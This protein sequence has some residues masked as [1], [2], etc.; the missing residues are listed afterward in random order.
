MKFLRE[1]LVHFLA[2]GALLFAVYGWL[3]RGADE[4]GPADR[5]V[6]VGEREMTWLAETWQRQRQRPPSAEELQG[7]LADYLREELLAR[8]ARALELDR[9]DT[10]VRRRLAQKMEFLLADTVSRA[11]PAEDDLRRL[12]A[13]RSDRFAAPARTSF[14]QVFVRAD[15]REG[16]AD[17]RASRLLAA[18]AAEPGRG[19]AE[20]GDPTLLPAEVVAADEREIA[21]QFGVDFARA[22]GELT[23]GEWRGP[24]RSAF[25]LHLVRVTGR[26]DGRPRGYDEVR[27]ELVAEWHRERDEA[28]Q[29]AYFAGLLR[30]YEIEVAESLRPLLAPALAA[31]GG[32]TK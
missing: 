17:E 24:L 10:V 19:I 9:D 13:A 26:E 25:G 3:G 2:A 20:L 6:V 29:Q 15:E 11:E 7:L 28:A 12:F 21:A 30:E 23:P 8:E 27:D 32:A 31:V 5:R 4:A 22:V 1:P 18:L 16:H 14:E